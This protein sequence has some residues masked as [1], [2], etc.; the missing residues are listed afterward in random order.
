MMNAKMQNNLSG[1]MNSGS[2][3]SHKN[4][5]AFTDFLHSIFY[6][7]KNLVFCLIKVNQLIEISDYPKVFLCTSSA[8]L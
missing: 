3:I 8:F 2:K 6:E 1:N 5:R 4:N 7:N